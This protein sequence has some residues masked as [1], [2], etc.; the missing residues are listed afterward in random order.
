MRLKPRRT[1][2]LISF[3]ALLLAI[4][5]VLVLYSGCQTQNVAAEHKRALGAKQAQINNLELDVKIGANERIVIEERRIKDKKQFEND[6]R[7]IE[8]KIAELQQRLN[9]QGVQR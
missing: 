4:I 6:K 2:S 1:I 9:D 8:A 5:A 7:I 3:D